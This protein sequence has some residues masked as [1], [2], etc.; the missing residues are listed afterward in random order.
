M[1]N[2]RIGIGESALCLTMS[3]ASFILSSDQRGR[4]HST[5][6]R[7]VMTKKGRFPTMAEVLIAIK[8]EPL[9]EDGYWVTSDEL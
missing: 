6:Q 1:R 9:E 8:I 4:V 3:R 5:R 2:M 7:T